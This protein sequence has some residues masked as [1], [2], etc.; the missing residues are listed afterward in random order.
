MTSRSNLQFVDGSLGADI[1]TERV[2][3]L[4][5]INTYIVSQV[6]PHLMP[7]VVHDNYTHEESMLR[8]IF[9]NT[10]KTLVRNTTSYFVNQASA[11]G[12][13]P[14]SWN[15]AIHLYMQPFK[16]HVTV[17]P[18]PGVTD[19]M[20]IVT[21]PTF[22]DYKVACQE[23]YIETLRK[24]SLVRSLYGIEREFDRYYSRL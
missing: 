18:R 14:N 13:L 3:E 8:H 6:N 5:N 21:D 10:S 22:E 15:D 9:F 19:Y 24:I 16:G 1:P 20:G 12:L 11:L 7:F 4:F 23:T 2:G 17:F